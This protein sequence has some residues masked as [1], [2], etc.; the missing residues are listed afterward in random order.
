ML[1]LPLLKRQAAPGR[2]L[3]GCHPCHNPKGISSIDQTG[4][5]HE[6]DWEKIGVCRATIVFAEE[7]KGNATDARLWRS[8][9]DDPDGGT[10]AA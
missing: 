1:F 6:R 9:L 4:S 5:Y 10:V 3:A 2:C 8:L 7:L